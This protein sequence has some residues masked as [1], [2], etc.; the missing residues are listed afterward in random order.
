MPRVEKEWMGLVPNSAQRA[1]CVDTVHSI[2]NMT[3]H[4][5]AQQRHADAVDRFA[6]LAAVGVLGKVWPRE[7]AATALRVCKWMRHALLEHVEL[8]A[9]T[10]R[11][12]HN[13]SASDIEGMAKLL[14]W[15]RDHE[16]FLSHST[17]IR[18]SASVMLRVLSHATEQGFGHKLV[19]L[20]LSSRAAM[21]RTD[22]LFGQVHVRRIENTD[23]ATLAS[24]LQHCAQLTHLDLS[25]NGISWEGLGSLLNTC[26]ALTHLDLG[27]NTLGYRAAE[28]LGHA[29]SG[30]SALR[31]LSVRD[32][33]MR[34]GAV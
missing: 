24:V 16:L 3:A 26:S 30:C 14:W 15:L 28:S 21:Q 8:V 17:S 10:L 11:A 19:H 27:H 20:N 9:L 32:N 23:L 34:P 33:G 12:E 18:T 29:L 2:D 6:E 4:H 31:H 7:R 25:C 5:S 22:A 1:D 13:A